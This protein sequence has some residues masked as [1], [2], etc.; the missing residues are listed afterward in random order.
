MDFRSI[1]LWYTF[2]CRKKDFPPSSCL[3]CGLYI[4]VS[5]FGARPLSPQLWKLLSIST[6]GRP[7]LSRT[8]RPVTSQYKNILERF[9]LSDKLQT[10]HYDC[11]R[12]WN[13]CIY[14]Y[15]VDLYVEAK[16]FPVFCTPCSR[17]K[18]SYPELAHPWRA[19]WNWK[20]GNKIIVYQLPVKLR[21]LC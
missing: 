12:S 21:T 13:Y 14:E 9:S 5:L 7:S 18:Q 19:A 4:W 11:W 20:P 16:T 15:V 8:L 3:S 2:F 6:N 10:N 17:W 1:A